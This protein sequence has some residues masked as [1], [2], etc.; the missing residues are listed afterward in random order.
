MQT[1]EVHTTIDVIATFDL[2]RAS[3]ADTKS[4]LVS[5]HAVRGWLEARLLEMTARLATVSSFPENDL[6][7]ASRTG[8]RSAAT[9]VKRAETMVSMPALGAALGAGQISTEHV[10]VATRALR[11]LKAA[12]RP[13]FAARAE[14][15]A[16][17]AAR[18]TPDEFDQSL[19]RET[20]QITA[21]DGSDLLIRQKRAAR[22]RTWIDKATGMWC[23]NGRFDPE[24]GVTMQGSIDAMLAARF[25][26]KA[27]DDCPD[28]PGEKQD[29]LRAQA[30][31]ALLQGERTGAGRP[32]V[33]IVVDTTGA[34]VRWPYGARLPDEVL[35]K[36]L[37]TARVHWV[38]VHCGNIVRAPGDLN[39]GRTTRLANRAQRRAL[40]ALYATCAIPGCNVR[41]EN[42][43]LHHLIWWRH[44]GTTDLHN[45]LPLCSR[46]HHAV[47]E[48]GWNIMLGPDR[49]LSVTLPDQTTMTTGPPNGN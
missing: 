15:L 30:L 9:V 4:G 24:A 26:D 38:D 10:D 39:L 45:L 49:A 21:G 34:T 6:A 11:R 12:D 48:Q 43:R 44:G 37:D 27:P 46:H 33:V 36:Y 13:G 29:W 25:A 31:V 8:Q 40:G 47:H 18:T 14:R 5:V 20:E 28:D 23:L 16:L 35:Q 22:L 32:E 17:I 1:A 7:V 2:E 19:Q 42:T 3:L 41:Y